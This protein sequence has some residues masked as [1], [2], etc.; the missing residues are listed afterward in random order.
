MDKRVASADAAVAAMQDGATILLGGFGLC[1][2]PENLIA[3][4]RRKGTKNLTLVSNNAGIDDFGIGVLLQSKQ[5]KKMIASYVGENKTFEQLALK[6]EIDVELN[7]QG[8]LA[9]R[10]RCGGAGIPAF[11]TPTGYGTLAADGKEIRQFNGR[12]HVL[13]PS[14]R[15]DFAFI[16]A[17]KG[18]R[19]G[20][21]VYRKTARNYNAV[22]AT[23]ADY[24]IAE[25]EKIVELG[26]LDPDCVHTPGIYVDAIFQGESYEKRIERRT[27]QKR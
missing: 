19:W 2:I 10:I 22:M 12:P 24:V 16:K 4:L 27:V 9:E 8:T 26:A 20:N 5:V 13:V 11:F 6:K 7:P 3:A 25:V 23:A 21:L 14:L 18:D 17:W 15:G 1:G